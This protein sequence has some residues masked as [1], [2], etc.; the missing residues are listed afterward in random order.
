MA[1]ESRL[2]DYP[3][4][5]FETIT[6]ANAAIG[7]TASLLTNARAAYLTVEGA[8]LRYRIDG[9]NPTDAVGH[10]VP[11]GGSVWFA[12]KTGL[13]LTQ[14]RMIRTGATSATVS[15]TIY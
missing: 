5:S 7:I 4:Q 1:N 9:T 12:D 2:T 8:S 3:P 10:L 11:N 13:T 14:L 6:V 15:V